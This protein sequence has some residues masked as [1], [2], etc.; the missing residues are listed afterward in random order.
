LKSFLT[1]VVIWHFL[2][3]IAFA[4]QTFSDTPHKIM[5]VGDSVTGGSSGN[6]NSAPSYRYFIY[7]H[8]RDADHLAYIKPVGPYYGISNL[9]EEPTCIG[10]WEEWPLEYSY[11]AAIGGITTSQL[12]GYIQN[13]TNT[14]Q[15][16][17]ILY[18]GVF[19]D[20]GNVTQTDIEGFIDNA[21][22]GKS[23]VILIMGLPY[24]ATDHFTEVQTDQFR[25][26]MMAAIGNRQS[27]KSPIY[28]VDHMI[29]WNPE[30]HAY[31][32]DGTS[33]NRYPNMDGNALLAD[34]WLEKLKEIGFNTQD[35]G[36]LLVTIEPATA[37]DAGARW[38]RTS[39]S[40]WLDSGYTETDL[41][42]GSHTI[43]FKDIIGWIKPDNQTVTV[44][45]GETAEITGLYERLAY[46]VTP[47]GGPGGS[48]DPDTLQ[49]VYHGNTASFTITPNIGYTAFVGGTCPGSLTDN[50]YTTDPIISD[51]N[52]EAS[53]TLN[54]Y[55]VSGVSGTGGSISP[56]SQEVNHGYTAIFSVE[57]NTG[58]H[59]SEV[60]G[61]G[62]SLSENTYTTGPIYSACT[63]RASFSLNKYYVSI[64]ADPG[65]GGTATGAGTYS[66]GDQVTVTATA[67]TGY[68]FINWTEDGVEVSTDEAYTF[69]A[70]S[71]RNLQ[72]NFELNQYTVSVAADPGQGGT[73]TG[74]DIYSHG[75]QVTVTATANTGYTFIS[76]TEDGEGISTDEAYTFTAESERNLLA[77]FELNQ[78]T[79]SV[80][81]DPGQG[82]T[83]T[84]ADIYSHGDQVTV[85][86]AAN[87][88][89]TFISWTEDGDEVSTDEAYTF[90]AES[91]R[92]L[93]A[94]FEL[95]HYTVFVAAD[96]WEGGIADGAGS[97][98]Y[99]TTATVT[100]TP[101]ISYAFIN[102]TEGAK[103]LSFDPEYTFIITG[104]RNLTANFSPFK[105]KYEI[106]LVAD[107][108]D[109]GIVAGG[110]SYDHAAKVTVIA[111]P[112]QG[113]GFSGWYESGLLIS[114]N[115]EYCF[116][117]DRDRKLKGCFIRSGLP[118]VLMLLLDDETIIQ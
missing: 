12:A 43:E 99:G 70:E 57:A 44:N 116:S 96:P 35:T 73:V 56:N 38:R 13:W 101:Y 72:A 11:H 29:G 69:T 102:W 84:G 24:Y 88:G 67:N 34:N 97:Y 62:G 92:N 81:A 63:V 95:N 50:T 59:I 103:A 16:D 89:Y 87:I 15:P 77:N 53:F 37:R 85:T 51:C 23:D 75:D 33:T 25:N 80:T 42:A 64:A 8:W 118:G 65:Q 55:S 6:R 90:T 22:A 108:E 68:T 71:E 45:D 82:G 18:F 83:V 105:D 4:F 7:T 14:Y 36:S 39:T 26:R 1:C 5:Y 41:P 111:L 28:W 19:N 54:T 115:L 30:E 109:G 17:V 49:M 27:E 107:H 106:T 91:E 47:I 58:F 117:A 3:G 76:W 61:C 60:T 66:H 2:T 79:V 86:A 21:R 20:Q 40:V 114:K 32:I 74:A 52:V 46:E 93:L 104:E 98:P 100:A 110:G 112:H 78:Y 31:G 94:N 9:N 48:I 10:G 113:W